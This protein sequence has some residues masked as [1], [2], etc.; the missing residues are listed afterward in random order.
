MNVKSN[1]SFFLSDFEDISENIAIIWNDKK[2]SYGQI[3]KRISY[4]R[5]E[6]R[7]IK[8]S[9]IVGLEG[10]FS[11]ETISILFVLIE[12]NVIVVPLDINHSPKNGKKLRSLNSRF[13]LKLKMKRMLKLVKFRQLIV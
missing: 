8:P 5:K 9:T 10:D 13:I 7:N 2:I 12:K 3:L 1:I 11:P 6:L 4:W